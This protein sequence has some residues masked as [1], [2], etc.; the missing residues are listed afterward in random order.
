LPGISSV[1][2]LGVP[3]PLVAVVVLAGVY[4]LALARGRL[5]R[6]ILAV[7]TQPQLAYYS[8]LSTQRVA[9]WVFLGSALAC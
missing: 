3:L 6:E 9:V 2:I 8:G 5:G 7:G 1:L 4:G